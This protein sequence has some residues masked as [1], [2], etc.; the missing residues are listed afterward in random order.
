MDQDTTPYRAAISC[1]EV[2][3]LLPA[4][5]DGLLPIDVA[6]T[7]TDHLLACNR[8]R[9]NN[10]EAVIQALRRETGQDAA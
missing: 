4:Y 5:I 3:R 9:A 6:Q 8:H 2:D 10:W 1:E 7:V